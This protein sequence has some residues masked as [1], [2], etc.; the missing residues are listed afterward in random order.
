MYSEIIKA[1]GFA[2]ISPVLVAYMTIQIAKF[3]FEKDIKTKYL[4][5]KDKT[6]TD[7]VTSLCIMLTS[8]WDI[9]NI[10]SWIKNGKASKDDAAIIQKKQVATDTFHKV[11]KDSYLQLGLMGLYYGTEIVDLIAQLQSELNRMV[12]EDDFTEFDNWDNF[13]KEKLLPI[14]QKVHD[15]LRN[16]VF[17]KTK[18]FCLITD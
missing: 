2:I 15:E 17:E 11:T 16:T 6:A 7:I 13:R 8:M 10:N 18:S 14:L 12:F 5:V 1:I 9:A 3:H 4:F